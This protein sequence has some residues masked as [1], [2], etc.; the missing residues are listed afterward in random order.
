MC[1][2]DPFRG[3]PRYWDLSNMRFPTWMPLRSEI[4]AKHSSRDNIPCSRYRRR[5][6]KDVAPVRRPLRRR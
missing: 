6:V 2:G 5:A 3:L 4:I 1:P